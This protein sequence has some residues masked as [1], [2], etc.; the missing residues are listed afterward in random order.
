MKN[1]LL[2]IICFLFLSS[3]LAEAPKLSASCV[4][5][6]GENGISS[7]TDWPN[8]AGQQP[9]YLA[10][11]MIAFRDGTRVNAAMPAELLRGVS[12]QQIQELA[13]YYSQL[14]KATPIS[15]TDTSA[16]LR[17]RAQC[18]SCH[19]MDGNTV[20]PMW[21]NLAGQQE[22]YLIKQLMDYKTGQRQHPI[23]HVIANELTDQQIVDVAKYYNQ[24]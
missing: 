20:S 10:K 24:N 22:G 16:G 18:V 1:I 3:A 19:G 12:D 17:V 23:M 13:A 21:A 14:E 2:G 4:A 7:N 8:L 6:H 15:K 5:C 11:E 9:G